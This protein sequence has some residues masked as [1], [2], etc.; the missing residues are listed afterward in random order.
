M[1]EALR[2][3][4]DAFVGAEVAAVVAQGA[5]EMTTTPASALLL[6]RVQH[7]HG[8]SAIRLGKDRSGVGDAPGQQGTPH[9]PA[10]VTPYD[11]P[12][13]RH[14]GTRADVD[15]KG[16]EDV[17]LTRHHSHLRGPRLERRYPLLR[18]RLLLIA[19]TT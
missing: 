12:A 15:A 7:D 3:P 19:P 9:Q 10:L 1:G 13:S 2:R 8:R 11:V 5:A 6:P 16:R 17:P 18:R 14:H 4:T